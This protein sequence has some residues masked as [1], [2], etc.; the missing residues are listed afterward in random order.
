MR[1]SF[2]TVPDLSAYRS[3]S[4]RFEASHE[5]FAPIPP[6]EADRGDLHVHAVGEQRALP[7]GSAEALFVFD[8]HVIDPAKR[9]AGQTAVNVRFVHQLHA[10]S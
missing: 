7:G 10:G 4:G 8:Q 6:Y 9:A 5:G 3:V 2:G 1:R